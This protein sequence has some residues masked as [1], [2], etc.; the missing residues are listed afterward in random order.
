MGQDL[1]SKPKVK[2]SEES[3]FP[4]LQWKTKGLNKQD[5]RAS[6]STPQQEEQAGCRAAERAWEPGY[7]HVCVVIVP[8]K[9]KKQDKKMGTDSAGSLSGGFSLFCGC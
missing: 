1:F 5:V 8:K 4:L 6:E 3:S 7:L 9:N 2:G